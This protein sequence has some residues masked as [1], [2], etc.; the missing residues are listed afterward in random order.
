MRYF[1]LNN[2]DSRDHGYVLSIDRSVLPSL[3]PIFVTIPRRAGAYVPKK[4]SREVSSLIFTIKFGILGDTRADFRARVRA[5]AEWIFNAN[6]S[7]QAVP[8]WLSD[9]PSK[10]YKVWI[11]GSTDLE[12]FEATGEVEF[13][14]IAPDPFA[15][16]TSLNTTLF[17]TANAGNLMLRGY[18]SFESLEAGANF[19]GHS[20]DFIST[21]R[22]MHG[23]KTLKKYTEAGNN[24]GIYMGATST[25]YYIP[26]IGGQTYIFS[27]HGY[28]E[29][30]FLTQGHVAFNTAES[31]KLYSSSQITM[32]ANEWTR[33]FQIVTAP[34]D[35]TLAL[36]RVDIDQEWTEVWFD[37]LQ[38]EIADAGQTLP[39]DW[40]PSGTVGLKKQIRNNGTYE[41]FPDFRLVPTTNLDYVKLTDGKGKYIL[42]TGRTFPAW[43][44]IIIDNKK[45][46][47]Y[48][49]ASGVSL[50]ENLTIDSTFFKLEPQ[51]DYMLGIETSAGGGMSARVNWQEK[52]L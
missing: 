39:T 15:D 33:H 24:N 49:E 9:E 16:S 37:C 11:E 4:R 14:M 41:T 47:V 28:A 42:L 22:A 48:F 6:A 45:G 27:Y 10:I 34:L 30:P 52:H 44:N 21:L 1:V 25:D 50:M 32:P 29:K 13:N 12:E 51:T 2:I 35:A 23:E 43:T 36:P 8:M 40:K 3:E 46:E 20:Q 18:D 38:F 5:V 26:V 7:G 31:Q 19:E 17:D